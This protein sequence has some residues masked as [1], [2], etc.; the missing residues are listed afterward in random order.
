MGEWN[1]SGSVNGRLWT[2]QQKSAMEM[3][4]RYEVEVVKLALVG[5]LKLH[6]DSYMYM[7]ADSNTQ[8]YKIQIW[9][10]WTIVCDVTE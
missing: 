2:V 1:G 9:Q 4:W 3:M 5:F 6:A 10:Y 7:D 8:S